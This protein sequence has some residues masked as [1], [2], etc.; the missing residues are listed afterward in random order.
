MLLGLIGAKGSG[1]DT[2]ALHLVEKFGFARLAFADK[3]YQEVADAFG[4]T[5][6][7]LQNRDTKETPTL[8][9]SLSQCKD[10]DFVHVAWRE[11]VRQ[12]ANAMVKGLPEVVAAPLRDVV[13]QRIQDV[14]EFLQIPLSPRTV[15]QWWGTEYRRVFCGHDS[16]WLDEIRRQLKP[17][18]RYV[19]TDVRF[20]NEANFVES[21]DGMLGRI[22]RP[23]LQELEDKALACGAPTAQ[24]KSETELRDRATAFTFVNEE[25]GL[26]AFYADAVRQLKL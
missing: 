12:Y 11:L 15:L 2:L 9:L 4:V 22:I 6:E 13:I 18:Q 14:R 3:L 7:F 5:V 10:A 25:N 20:A 23:Y 8:V 1:K 21:E 16:Y 24:H 26:E 19:I 17:G